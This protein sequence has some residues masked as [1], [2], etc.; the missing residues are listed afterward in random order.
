MR[1]GCISDRQDPSSLTLLEL[2]KVNEMPNT[3]MRWRK[4]E[5][6]MARLFLLL[7]S[8]RLVR[9]LFIGSEK[10]TDQNTVWKIFSSLFPKR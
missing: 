2:V 7:E 9:S 6:K 8:E 1:R 4:N 10:G 3:I 5:D